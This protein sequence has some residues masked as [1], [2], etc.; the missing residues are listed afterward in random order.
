M[1]EVLMPEQ[2]LTSRATLLPLVTVTDMLAPPPMALSPVL[3]EGEEVVGGG[4]A[5]VPM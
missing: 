5:W 2:S 4:A 3:E 1:V